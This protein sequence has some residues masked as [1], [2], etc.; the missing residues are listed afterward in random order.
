MDCRV[1]GADNREDRKFCRECGNPLALTC[2]NCG[3]ENEVGDK[4]CGSCGQN[5]GQAETIPPAPTDISI[6]AEKRFV[7]VLFADLVGYTTYTEA[8]DSE[9]VRDMLTLY[10]E[11]SRE[12]VERFGGTID[13]FI[14]DAVMGVWGA[15]GAREDDA[16]RAVRA[17][18]EL[19]DMVAALGAELN[20]PEL[21]LRAGVNSGSAVVGPGGNDQGMVVGDLVNTAARLQSIAD[22]ATVFVGPSTH[23]V[24]S[25]AIHYE[26]VGEREVKGKTEAVSAWKALR[27]AGL[28]GGRLESELRHPPFVGREREMRLLKDELS[29]VESEQRARLVSIIG[30]GGVGKTRLAEEFKNHIDGFTDDVYWHQGRSPSYGDGVAFWALGEMVRRRAG[31]AEGEEPT[32]ARTR[33]RTCV[34]EF[35]PGEED[36]RW[37]EPRL[38]GLLGLADMPPGGRDELFS[39]LRSFFQHI[40][41]RGTT[42]LV[43]EDL[44]WADSGLLDFISELADRSTR[45]PLLIVTLG[46]PDVLDRHPTWGSQHRNS[47]SVR[48]APLTEDNMRR[49]VIEHLPGVDAG[50]VTRIVERSAGFPLYAVEMVRMLAASGELLEADGEWSF[51]GD[52]DSLALPESL[53]AV[54]GARLDR[55][56]PLQRSLLQDGAVLGQSFTM[57]SLQS[58]RGD[59]GA[60]LEMLLRG[61]TQLEILDIA[62]DPRSPERG[63][64]RFVQSLIHEVAY[65]RLGRQDRRDKHLAAAAYF[66]SF[67]DPELAGVVAGHYMGAFNATPDGPERDALAAQ[68]LAG[69]NEAARRAG[70]LGS[71]RRAEGLLE[72]AISLST[73]PD[74]QAGF[75]LLAAGMAEAQ[76]EVERAIS[77]AEQAKAHYAATGNLTGVRRA[78]TTHSWILNSNFRSDEALPVIKPIYDELDSVED[79]VAIGVAAE[80][81]R[82]LS[83]NFDPEAIAAVERLLPGAAALSLDRIILESL[84]TKGT[85]LAVANRLTEARTVLVGAAQVAEELGLLAT[86]G[87]AYNN[88]GAI[89]YID[90]PREAAAFSSRVEDISQRLGDHGWTVR[91]TRDASSAAVRDGRFDEAVAALDSFDDDQLTDFWKAS[92]TADRALIH[93]W[94]GDD[95]AAVDKA[96]DA[97]AFFDDVADPQLRSGMD[98]YRAHILQFAGRWEEAFEAAMSIDRSTTGA[99]LYEAAQAA[100]WTGRL[101]WIEQVESAISETSFRGRLAD[102]TALLIE[103]I[104][105]GLRGE[106]DEAAARFDDVIELFEPIVLGYDLAMVRA[107]YAKV[108]GRDHPRAAQAAQHAHDWLVETGS[109]GVMK[110]WSAGLPSATESEATA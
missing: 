34:A 6:G 38:E 72:Q 30:E 63:Q 33:L 73:D 110:M 60:D 41:I 76:S 54:I 49:M 21:V 65:R 40:S 98:Q 78:A 67:D 18:M 68:A 32:R 4:F 15:T 71:H 81:A 64:Y 92:F 50:V 16:E 29:A 28:V 109:H 87:R 9:D 61:L 88:L 99:G 107:L 11:R 46:R 95:P 62:D 59:G 86:A 101:D 74:Q 55:L 23:S 105:A 48:L 22:P 2:P 84:V 108:V 96:L 70:A 17:A 97:V 5:L 90:N 93:L 69:L 13:K 106:R 75:R 77:Y 94:K 42:V 85:A 44:H 10:F 43:F 83:L 102:G 100:A 25:H 58:I 89:L 47:M 45:S 37:I 56:D 80:A 52:L 82:S 19:V 8:R 104:A 1:C 7:S 20:H 36:R 79:E 12:I 27:V 91:A 24:T 103:G 31:I 39:A 35:V 57:N 26:S 53:Q 66:E 14:G 51:R 3:T